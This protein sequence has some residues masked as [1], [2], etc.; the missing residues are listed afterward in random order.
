MNLL[1]MLITAFNE[2]DGTATEYKAAVYGNR[3]LEAISPAEQ[4]RQRTQWQMPS[5]VQTAKRIIGAPIRRFQ[6]RQ[7]ARQR[8]SRYP[9]LPVTTLPRSR[10]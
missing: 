4:Y 6:E 10:R 1:N 9:S 7:A 2:I 5:F 8:A 3:G